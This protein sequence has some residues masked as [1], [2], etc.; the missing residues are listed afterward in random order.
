MTGPIDSSGKFHFVQIGL[1]PVR[2][3]EIASNGPFIYTYIGFQMSEVTIQD[4]KEKL[5]S[6]ITQNM[7]Q[8]NEKVYRWSYTSDHFILNLLNEPLAIL[9][10][11]IWNDH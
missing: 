11:L 8:D 7:A 3:L 2:P 5:Q 10:N 6:L 1:M 4:E 9:I